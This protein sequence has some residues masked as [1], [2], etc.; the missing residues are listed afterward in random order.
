MSRLDLGD[1]GAG[2]RKG[3][4]EGITRGVKARE[5]RVVTIFSSAKIQHFITENTRSDYN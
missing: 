2:R 1:L 5:S 3:E 4:S